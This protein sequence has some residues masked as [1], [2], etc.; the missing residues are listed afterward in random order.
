[1]GIQ[2]TGADVEYRHQRFV[3]NP[4]LP[5]PLPRSLPQ[6][7]LTLWLAAWLRHS[8]PS[9]Q[10]RVVEAITLQVWGCTYMYAEGGRYRGREGHLTSIAESPATCLDP[11][12]PP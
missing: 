9:D 8:R 7:A 12:P 3:H 4:Y 2:H 11:L 5:V 6:E 1:V 10:R